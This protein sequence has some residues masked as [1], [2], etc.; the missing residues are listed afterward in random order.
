MQEVMKVARGMVKLP[1]KSLLFNKEIMMR[2][3][4]REELLRVNERELEALKGQ[5]RGEESLGAIR[6]FKEETERKRREKAEKA[7]AKL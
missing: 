6:G 3:G 5:V 7:K 2:G 1:P 4:L